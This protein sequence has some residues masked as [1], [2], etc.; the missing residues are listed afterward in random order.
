MAP[1]GLAIEISQEIEAQ[2]GIDLPYKLGGL[3]QAD[4]ALV[5]VG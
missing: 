3:S 5:S 4:L 1:P 2:T